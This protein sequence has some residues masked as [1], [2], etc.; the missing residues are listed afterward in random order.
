V[1]NAGT[2]APWS[3]TSIADT[4]CWLGTTKDFGAQQ[5]FAA[6]GLQSRVISTPAISASIAQ[7]TNAAEAEALTYTQGGHDFICWTWPSIPVTWCYDLT[8]DAWHQRMRGVDQRWQARG[9]CGF[10]TGTGSAAI[11]VGQVDTPFLCELRLDTS[12]DQGTAIGTT[13]VITRQRTAPYLSAENQWLFLYQVELGMEAAPGGLPMH[14]VELFLST[15]AG[16]SFGAGQPGAPGQQLDG[17]AVAQW[18]QLGRARADR[19]VLA[20]R[21]QVNRP[22]VWGPGLWLRT[23]PGTGR[24]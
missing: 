1:I 16:Q 8:E 11:L 2:L 15:N 19:L 3:I 5:V 22:C 13:T 9:A 24:L 18:F 12:T 14:D 17:Y 7:S 20:I 4:V 6:S 23:A 10:V 21:Q